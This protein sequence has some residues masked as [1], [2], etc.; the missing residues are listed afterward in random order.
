LLSITNAGVTLADCVL[1][2]R[3]AGDGASGAEGQAGMPM[4]GNNGNSDGACP[5][6]DGGAGGDGGRGGGGAGGI[7]VGAVHKGNAPTF[8]NPSITTGSRG[9]GGRGENIGRHGIDG[10]DWPMLEVD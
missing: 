9:F 3:D 5:G 6:G 2:T 1:K 10:V 8:T 7:S 4:G